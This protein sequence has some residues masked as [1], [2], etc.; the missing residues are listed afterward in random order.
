MKA[1]KIKPKQTNKKKT[2]HEGHNAALHWS[3]D[4]QYTRYCLMDSSVAKLW[5]QYFF[6]MVNSSKLPEEQ[7]F[8]M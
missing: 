4:F 7:Y 3:I 5:F 2:A 1:K 8:W 6:R